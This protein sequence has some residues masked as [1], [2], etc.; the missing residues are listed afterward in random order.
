MKRSNLIIYLILSISSESIKHKST[1]YYLKNQLTTNP[2][3]FV[4][5]NSIYLLTSPLWKVN[6]KVSCKRDEC[7]NVLDEVSPFHCFNYA[8]KTTHVVNLCKKGFKFAI[9]WNDVHFQS[10]IKERER[11]R[12]VY[13]LN[14]FGI[15]LWWSHQIYNHPII[16]V[17]LIDL[18]LPKSKHVPNFVIQKTSWE[19]KNIYR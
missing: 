19:F 4:H 2:K 11:E 18:P 7:Q 14:T 17:K 13:K 10:I 6:E 15:Y 1:H 3:R 9:K 8:T 16:R 12:K 5:V